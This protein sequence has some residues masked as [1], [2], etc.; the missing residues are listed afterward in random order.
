MK[1]ILSLL[2]AVLTG[3]LLCSC[4]PTEGIPIV[5]MNWESS[6]TFNKNSE[7]KIPADAG[8]YEFTCTS[9]S[10]FTLIVHSK[11]TLHK[12]HG[13]SDVPYVFR[14]SWYEVLIHRNKMKVTVEAN[15]TGESRSLSLEPIIFLGGSF[16][17]LIQSTKAMPPA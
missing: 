3:V 13:S 16:F 8:V 9:H 17:K 14:G 15:E 7:S 6:L 2:L 4:E 5:P 12:S 11:D 10:Y 1:P